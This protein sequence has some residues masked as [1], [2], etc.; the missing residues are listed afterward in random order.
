MATAKQ[1]RFVAEYLIDRNGSAAYQRAGFKATGNVAE[2]AASRLLR[3]PEIQKL[4]AAGEAKLR[5]RVEIQQQ[6]V[7]DRLWMIANADANELIQHRRLC[8][9]YCYGKNFLYQ[10]TKGERARDYALWEA[11]QRE[12]DEDAPVTAFDEMGGTGY[13]KLKAP[14]PDC[15]ECFGEGV[16][17]VYV[18]DTRNL[19]GAARMAYAG[20]HATK[21]GIKV[22]Q[23]SKPD[24]LVKVGEHLGMFRQVHDHKHSG[25]VGLMDI[26]G[27]IS[28]EQQ[29]RVAAEMMRAAGYVIDD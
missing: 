26:A 9:R 14:N 15:P 28:P 7:I 25:A 4:I 20:V 13:H 19:T 2:T 12:A 5:E 27:S 24:A 21:D 23:H 3:D 1:E 17:D 22:L 16:P 6:D 11:E 8:C 10:R 29:L 18:P